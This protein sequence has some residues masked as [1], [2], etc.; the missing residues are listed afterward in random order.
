MSRMRLI[1]AF[2]V[3]ALAGA[4]CAENKPVLVVYDFTSTF[5]KG[6]M[7]LWVA[8]IVRGHAQRSGGYVGNPKITLD[9]IL[10]ARNYHPTVD[11]DPAELAK[12]TRDAFG[13]DILVWGSVAQD[14][15]GFKVRFR[16]W[17]S[18]KDGAPE[19]V[20]DET[21]EC[22]G[23][24]FIPLA[25]DDV[26]N[27]SGDIRDWRAEWTRLAS[28]LK[29]W[30]AVLD[31]GDPDER[32]S[33]E[34]WRGGLAVWQDR[35]AARWRAVN[36]RSNVDFASKAL[37]AYVKEILDREAELMGEFAANKRDEKAARELQAL[38]D[39]CS[40]SI[41]AWLDDAEAEKRWKDGKNLVINGDF[42][43]GQET[44]A[45][46][47]FP[48]EDQ[49]NVVFRV[50]DPDAKTGKCLRF[51]VSE[52]IA[53]NEGMMCYSASFEVE[54]GATYRVRWRFKTTGTS[55]KLWIKGYD[56][57]PKAFGFEEQDREVWRSRKDP[58]FHEGLH[59]YTL[60]EWTE[61]GHD[62]VP[63]VDP[64]PLGKHVRYAKVML[65]AYTSA[66]TVWWDDIV[67]RKIKDAPIRPK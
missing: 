41:T 46:N 26:L 2:I 37:L 40:R 38:A 59:E 13:G 36:A 30:S 66:G 1:P 8:E 33:T 42:E 22:P 61:Y 47:W 64:G 15:L 18:P 11:T 29:E 4:A 17:R 57:F 63:Y 58:Q 6:A 23:K 32:L 45:A 28:D 10:G 44:V 67:I 3:L 12:F 62:F 24:Q 27:A 19:K 53:F 43:A 48:R 65:Y 34:T 54:Q 35:L 55:V 31:P 56:H 14:G 20:L 39:C 16:V 7:G 60:N 49:K 51:D 50:A 21:K 5:D 9:E 52:K 25:A